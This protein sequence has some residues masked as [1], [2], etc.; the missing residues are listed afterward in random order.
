MFNLVKAA[1]AG[2]LGSIAEARD[3]QL[4]WP[5]NHA[6]PRTEADRNSQLAA[7]V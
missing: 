6:C 3:F 4:V 2:W 5:H 1:E 7:I